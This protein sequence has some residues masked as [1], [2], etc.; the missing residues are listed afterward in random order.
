[1]T[2]H[3][4]AQLLS[5]LG[6]DPGDSVCVCHAADGGAMGYDWTTVSRAPAIAARH[7]GSAHVWFGV[8]PMVPPVGTGRGKSRDVVGV[9]A[10]YADLDY[11]APGKPDGMAPATAMDITEALSLILGGGPSAI[12]ASGYGIQPYFVLDADVPV[13]EGALLLARWRQVVMNVAAAHGTCV[14]S[15]VYDL[16]RILRV[17]GPPNLKYSTS[18]RTGLVV[19]SGA[20]PLSLAAVSVA[21][22]AYAPVTDS[23][24]TMH[25]AN[26]A[27][28][29]GAPVLSGHSGSRVFTDAE[30]MDFITEFALSRVAACPWGAGA[31]FWKVIWEA[32]MTCSN[33]V[34]MFDEED[35]KSL[36]R[37]AVAGG[38]DGQGTDAADEYQIAMGFMK[39]RE[40][41]ARRPTDA[42]LLDPFNGHCTLAGVLVEDTGSAEDGQD[43]PASA[44]AWIGKAGLRAVA[45]ADHLRASVPVGLTREDGV[46]VYAD[47]VYRIN[48]A[49][50]K[51]V[52]IAM[53]GNRWNSTHH[54]TIKEVVATQLYAER[55]GLAERMTEPLVN[56]TNGMLDLRTLELRPHDPAY[57]STFQ[58]AFDWQPT[59][60]C[61]TYLRW[62][63]MIDIVDQ[64][65][66]LEETV[67]SMF[68]PSR[69]P[70]KALFVFGPARSGKSTY[71]RLM[72]AAIG[73]EKTCGLSLQDLSDDKFAAANLYGMVLNVCADLS[74]AHV[75]D[76]SLFKKLTGQDLIHANRK[77]GREFTFTNSALFAFSGNTLPTVSESSRAYLERMKPVNFAN[78][79]AGA[80]DPRIEDAMLAEMPGIVARWVHR[81]HERLVRGTATATVARVAAQFAEASNRVTMWLASE[82]DMSEGYWATTTTLYD[83]FKRW[84]EQEGGAKP[85]GRTK[86]AEQLRSCGV[87]ECRNPVSKVRGWMAHPKMFSG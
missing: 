2:E 46:A 76:V 30:A 77:Y 49:A 27:R 58:L 22:D 59:A 15:G 37:E 36:L 14:D 83:A 54:K 11:A 73:P 82:V 48:D 35:L 62:V 43:G 50:L 16:A 79:F 21:L 28:M 65:I 13:V 29:T 6:R 1:M 53:L 74:A 47:G 39:G 68:D 40:W 78:S 17:P 31:D 63:A 44:Q 18:A 87:E 5:I 55:S 26:V 20:L 64:L 69:T 51:L 56:F 23:L 84:C 60:A 81:Y 19:P 3:P 70:P 42:E 24:R 32:A 41:L 75:E 71:L 4:F 9:R 8:Q 72:G 38:H 66:D 80:E 61:P 52:T 7:A 25:S 86:F 67:G 12:V 34:E 33:F 10:L 45:C 57:G 85:M